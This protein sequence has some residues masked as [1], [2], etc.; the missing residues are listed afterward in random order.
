M[1]ENGEPMA[2]YD[3]AFLIPQLKAQNE[4]AEA[5]I[6]N[7]SKPDAVFRYNIELWASG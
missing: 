2:G 4:G 6:K 3:A 1:E 7:Q 5:V